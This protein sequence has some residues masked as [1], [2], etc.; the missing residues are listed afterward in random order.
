MSRM[1]SAE[2]GSSIQ[3]LSVM[4]TKPTRTGSYTRIALDH[5][6]DKRLHRWD[7]QRPWLAIVG[8][9]VL[10]LEPLQPSYRLQADSLLLA[11]PLADLAWSDKTR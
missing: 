3:C 1:R 11:Y 4:R 9:D 10:G 2:M 6:A 8:S 5:V 7:G